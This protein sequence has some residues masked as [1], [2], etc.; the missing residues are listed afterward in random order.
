MKTRIAA[1]LGTKVAVGVGAAALAFGTAG[2][3][4]ALQPASDSSPSTTAAD[5]TTTTTSTT[6]TTLAPTTT[7]STTV[8]PTTT[9]VPGTTATASDD[10]GRDEHPDNFGAMVSEDARDGVL[11]AGG[12]AFHLWRIH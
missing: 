8:A 5:D 12:P 7:T 6:S 1:A 2:T 3:V 4:I 10:H 11:P 9:T